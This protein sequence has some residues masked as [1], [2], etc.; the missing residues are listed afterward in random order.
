M[1]NAIKHSSGPLKIWINISS[2]RQNG[3]EYAR[4]SIADNGPGISD[5][6]KEKL[7]ARPVRDSTNAAGHGLGLYLVKRL[8]EDQNGQVW[9]ED[10]ILGDCSQG[11]KF[12]VLIPA[13]TS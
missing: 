11:V 12:V 8:M 5:E 7:F 6:I 13:Y 9:A 10:R 2:E 3:K 1:G 4:I